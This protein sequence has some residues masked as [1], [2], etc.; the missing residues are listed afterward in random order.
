VVQPGDIISTWEV[1][2]P[3]G[4]GGFAQVW[5]VRHRILHSLHALKLLDPELAT[6]DR[7][8]ERFLTEGRILA[9]LRHPNLVPVTDV[10]AEPPARVGL[11]M[12]YVEGQPLDRLVQAG[13]LARTD[14]VR[15][16]RGLLDGMQHAHDRGIVHRDLKPANVI[17][18]SEPDGLRPVVLDFGIAKVLGDN[19]VSTGE[20]RETRMSARMGTPEYMSPEQ[21]ESSAKVDV[22]ADIWS[23][24]VILWEL[25]AGA[26]PFV[27]D[28]PGAV[29]VKVL[30]GPPADH[31]AIPAELMP[32]VRR[33]LARDP[34]DRFPTCRAF[35]EALAAV[36]SSAPVR[37]TVLDAPSVDDASPIRLGPAQ[38]AATSP[39]SAQPITAPTI[40]APAATPSSEA[41][42]GGRLAT[43]IA[44]G[45]VLVL[46]LL[47][48]AT[49]G[50]VGLVL[51]AGGKD[52]HKADDPTP[53]RRGPAGDAAG[54]AD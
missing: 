45:V 4:D 28:D 47:C 35:A 6:S 20:R 34:A 40:L 14:A 5:L 15:I 50:I 39:T 1:I 29:M 31:P 27:G 37:R 10:L 8:R 41:S 38:L 30:A 18:V 7:M 23:L 21:I 25:L 19:Q 26:P 42:S 33:A 53:G 44:I 2:R 9:Q 16:I 51:W 36:D 43:G 52:D 54:D 3:L 32:V 22:R 48:G 49:S 11:V 13:A 24:G 12:D 46:T 17:V